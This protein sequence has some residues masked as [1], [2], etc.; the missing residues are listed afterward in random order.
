MAANMPEAS[1]ITLVSKDYGIDTV[2]GKV[3]FGEDGEETL[4]HQ[5]CPYDV[6]FPGHIYI[7][8]NLLGVLKGKE[9][10]AVTPDETINV[11]TILE[12]FYKSAE[13]GKEE[14]ASEL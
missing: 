14:F 7:V 1:D 6:S 8:E 3:Y 9:Q 10:P 2:K 11:A 4:K 12:L 13:S 5:P